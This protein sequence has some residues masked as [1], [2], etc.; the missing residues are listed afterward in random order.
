GTTDRPGCGS[1][2]VLLRRQAPPFTLVFARRPPARSQWHSRLHA[3]RERT[4]AGAGLYR[5]RRPSA[6]T[7]CCNGLERRPQR[8]SNDRLLLYAAVGTEPTPPRHHSDALDP[9]PSLAGAQP[10][11]TT[12]P[13]RCASGPAGH[14]PPQL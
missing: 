9:W 7:R 6:G 10:G 2:R 14:F 13:P 4:Y 5:V 3:R 11:S 8:T 12:E 1:G